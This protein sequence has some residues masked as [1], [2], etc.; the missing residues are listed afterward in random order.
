M[1]ENTTTYTTIVDV[2]VEGGEGIKDLGDKVEG[3]DTK[4]KSLKSQIRETTV[5]LQELADGGKAGSA[6]FEK[7]S[8]KLDDLGDQQKKVAF[9]SGQIE[10]KLAALPG[11]IGAI[12][13][14]F[15]SLKDSIDTFGKGLTISLG[16]VGLLVAAFFAIKEAL[17]K[18]KEGQEGLSKAMSAF[19]SVLAPLFA[20]L[21]KVG[22]IVLPIITKG[23]EVLGQ[24]M[25]KVA[26]FFGVSNDKI[27]EVHGSLE[28]NNELVKKTAEANAKAAEELKKQ[29][30]EEAKKHVETLAKKKAADEKAAAERKKKKDEEDKLLADANKILVEAY[31]STLVDRDKELYA[32]GVKQQERLLALEKAGIKDTTSVLEQGRIEEAAI[33]KKFDDDI[34]KKKEDD[35]KKAGDDKKKLDEED[36]KREE[37]RLASYIRANEDAS[38]L[39]QAD[40]DLKRA[41]NEAT[42]ADQRALFDKT[43]ELERENIVA[44]GA[45]SD[46]ITAYDKETAAIRILNKKNEEAIKLQAVSSA[47]DSVAGLVDKNSAAGK[48][49]SIAQ[50]VINT[51][52]AASMALATYPPPFSFIA[53]AASIAAGLMNVNKIINTKVPSITGT[54]S[55]ASAGGGG[56]S[57][58]T[59]PTA[60]SISGMGAPQINTQGAQNGNNQLAQ[61]LAQASGKPVRAYVVGQDIQSQT[62]LDRRTNRAA[63]F[64]SGG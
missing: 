17:G 12:G 35:A 60:P 18:T 61:S 64:S 51:Y 2:K 42:F 63:T 31:I 24:V 44:S 8:N 30:E 57:M 41:N 38:L 19:N 5:A 1:A 6:E 33:N 39:A 50:A 49:I 29:K 27:K 16:I 13:K 23:F 40:F 28:Q 56:I 43:R 21:E 34:L 9:Q 54:G 45:S 25:S 58:G 22:M 53:A 11:P 3:S 7:L 48:A 20:I 4:F 14:G 55:V 36:K 47:L 52:Q 15:S 10:D 26:G 37:D 46:S 62:A 32:V 59:P